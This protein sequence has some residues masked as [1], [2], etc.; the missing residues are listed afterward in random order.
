[1]ANNQKANI[2][3]TMEGKQAERVLESLK[4]DA[5]SLG[6]QI[7]EINSKPLLSQE[8]IARVKELKT[9]LNQ[10]NRAI[11]EVQNQAK[12]VSAVIANMVNATE[13]QLGDALR[14]LIKQTKN[15]DRSTKEY[16]E[17]RKN[18]SLLKAELDKINQTGAKQITMFEQLGNTLKR[19]AAY[20]LV[21]F[22]FNQLRDSMQRVFDMNVRFSDQLADIQKT[23]GI[24]GNALAE[25]SNDINKIN[26][27][28]AVE[29]LNKLAYE[30]GKMG[31]SAKEDILG[32]VRAGNQ[33]RV[34]LS[35]DLGEDAIKNL[36]KLNTVLGVTKELGVEQGLL[37]TGSAINELGMNSTAAEGY[38]VDFAQRLGGIAAQAGLTVQQILALG[39]ATDQ[40]GQNVEVSATALNRFIVTVISKTEQVAK[41][42]KIP[43][44]DL[45]DALDRST[46]EGVMLVFQKMSERGGLA[47]LAPIMGDLGSNGARLTAVLSA[48]SANT[49]ILNSQIEISNKAFAEATSVTNE[50]NIRNENL[51]ATIE[52][53]GKNFTT[54]FM[55]SGFVEK[56][57]EIADYVYEATSNFD[58]FGNRIGGATSIFVTIIGWLTKLITFLIRNIDL[59]AAYA[60]AWTALS[61]ATKAAAVSQALLTARIAATNVVT[62]AGTVLSIAWSVALNTVQGNTIR[63]AAA[64][65]LFST[66]LKGIPFMAVASATAAVVT[67]IVALVR[68]FTAASREAK[69]FRKN[70]YEAIASSTAESTYLFDAL[71]K[72]NEGSAER[73][74]LIEEINRKYKDYL[75]NLITEKTTNEEL[76]IALKA[77]ND[78]LREK[79]ALE[80]KSTESAAAA[81]KQIQ[82]ELTLIDKMRANF[83]DPDVPTKRILDSIQGITKTMADEGKDFYEIWNA[84][85]TK[86][87]GSWGHFVFKND[88]YIR[89]LIN[90]YL[91]Y[92]RE[93]VEIDNRYAPFIT[94]A[95]NRPT[96]TVPGTETTGVDDDETKKQR[97]K[98]IEAALKAVDAYLNE[99]KTLLM[100]ARV[101][102][103]EFR[104]EMIDS[105]KK[106]NDQLEAIELEALNKRLAISG[107][108][109]EKRA[110]VERQFW[111]FKLEL[112][113]TEEKETQ[114]FLDNLNKLYDDFDLKG[115]SRE[116]REYLRQQQRFND[117]TKL[118][119]QA[120]KKRLITQEQYDRYAQILREKAQEAEQQ[121][122]KDQ[123][124]RDAAKEIKRLNEQ[125]KAEE[126][127]AAEKRINGI[128]NE[129]E[130]RAELLR[131]EEDYLQ[132]RLE[133]NGLSE[134]QITELKRKNYERQIQLLNQASR[135]QEQ[136]Y[137][138]YAN[139]VKSSIEGIGE[140]FGKLFSS[141]E[142]AAQQFGEAMIDLAFDSLSRLVDIWLLQLQIAAIKNTA[143]GAM[144]E[145]GTK[146]IAGLFTAAAVAGAVQGFL[147]VAKAGIKALIGKGGGGSGGGTGQRVVSR[148]GF[149]SGGFTG[150]G[151]TFEAAGVVHKGE[152]VVP[153]WQMTDP[154]SFS[155]VK[156]LESIR[157]TRSNSHPLPHHHGYD[158][159]GGVETEV[160]T[161]IIQR[162]PE[163]VAAI[164]Q[165]NTVVQS[166]QRNGIPASVNYKL[167]EEEANRV[168]NS[169]N[170]GTRKR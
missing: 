41:A 122:L 17:N 104:G 139:V 82:S 62:K 84:L 66:A 149:D 86:F 119:E 76:A 97:K 129:S 25:L 94:G 141:G 114:R 64:T 37:A 123:G 161:P 99:Q 126:L 75:P 132:Q 74:E 146:G 156:A 52:K 16:A 105:E 143:E 15:L 1:M 130:Y 154:V 59:L 56:I 136:I 124:E 44:Q 32:F 131:I 108:S 115:V 45:R 63:A 116:Q 53:I 13:K 36:M 61:V 9:E 60:A 110:E 58:E 85:S 157:Q 128:Y 83:P 160:A 30:A 138:Q 113:T 162:D 121:Y 28:T 137:K 55:N 71:R 134:E 50:Y 54:A 169:R 5:E 145:V 81:K 11:R 7:S 68:Q 120:L 26:T 167:I 73:A 103:T 168:N 133:I 147:Q 127:A 57:K 163:L 18:I 142:N 40:L 155:Y 93:L 96:G 165:L 87:D 153:K 8:D 46:W 106:Y 12:D 135:R 19:L 90:G 43:L 38:L 80:L 31:L 95:T 170:R 65:R 117:G 151:A 140:A 72:T 2:I 10:T 6:K 148:Q 23:T 3:V 98:R 77:I 159:G 111:D 89:D 67:G 14:T 144:T 49:E 69:E 150:R 42:L 158:E 33:I 78:Q 47:S 24:T 100:K 112:F 20:V 35:A 101:E 29:Q 27:R 39:S 48:L 92:K 152:Y 4:K 166:L 107:L 118:L 91:R 125:Q 79:T 164:K 34:A 102:Q 70:M 22:G 109:A 21:Y 51:A 88:Q